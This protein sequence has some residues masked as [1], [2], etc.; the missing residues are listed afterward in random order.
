MFKAYQIR[1]REDCEMVKAE[2]LFIGNARKTNN[3][4]SFRV[5]NGIYKDILTDD[6]LGQE[7]SESFDEDITID[8]ENH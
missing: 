3:E 1:P 5:E 7:D 2:E 6:Q 4:K 8:K